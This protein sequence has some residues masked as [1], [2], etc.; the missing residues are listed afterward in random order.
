[1]LTALGIIAILVERHRTRGRMAAEEG[2]VVAPLWLAIVRRIRH[3]RGSR[4]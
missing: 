1:V 3:D 2:V 4:E